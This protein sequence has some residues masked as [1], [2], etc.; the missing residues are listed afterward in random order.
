[1]IGREREAKELN[2]LYNSGR[3]ELVAI[4]GSSDTPVFLRQTRRQRG[5]CRRS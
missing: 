3:A 2:N 4:Y 1:M 5:Y